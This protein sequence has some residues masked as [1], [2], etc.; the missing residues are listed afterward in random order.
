MNRFFKGK[1]R[2]ATTRFPTERENP[3]LNDCEY[4]QA[5]H[6]Y[7]VCSFPPCVMRDSV[8]WGQ[9]DIEEDAMG[10]ILI[11]HGSK[12]GASKR[13]ADEC[14]RR[15]RTSAIRFKDCADTALRRADVVIYFGPVFAGGMPGLRRTMKRVAALPRPPRVIIVTVGLGDPSLPG[16]TEHLRGIVRQQV[17]PVHCRRS[18]MLPPARRHRLHTTKPDASHHDVDDVPAREAH[19]P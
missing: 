11:V 18:R 17:A 9:A 7:V 6:P 4:R 16:N 13:Y 3:L 8:Q 5:P 12:Y 19:T 14:A 2:S 1:H 15:L 10:T